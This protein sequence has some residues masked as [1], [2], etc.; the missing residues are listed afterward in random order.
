[1]SL[2]PENEE[3]IGGTANAL[4]ILQNGCLAGGFEEDSRFCERIE[5]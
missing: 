4:G 1:M 3:P 2:L 5:L